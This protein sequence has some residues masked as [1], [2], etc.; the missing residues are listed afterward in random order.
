MSLMKEP[1]SHD[2]AMVNEL[3]DDWTNNSKRPLFLFDETRWSNEGEGLTLPSNENLYVIIS[4]TVGEALRFLG[5]L[6]NFY[7]EALPETWP[8][9]KKL[10]TADGLAELKSSVEK[11]LLQSKAVSAFLASNEVVKELWGSRPSRFQLQDKSTGK[12]RSTR[13][14]QRS[15][16]GR[17]TGIILNALKYVAIKMGNPRTVDAVIDPSGHSAFDQAHSR[18]PGVVSVADAVRLNDGPTG[19]EASIK[20]PTSFRLMFPGKST[21]LA[22]LVMLP[23]CLARLLKTMDDNFIDALRHSA[24]RNAENGEPRIGCALGRRKGEQ[25][26]MHVVGGENFLHREMTHVST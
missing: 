1:T 19:A 25:I 26:E 16:G 21:Y 17:E 18:D 11:A 7:P 13:T 14:G 6:H 4:T 5:E 24:M 23:D 10:W 20:T 15:F 2:E 3:V 9:S 22:G 8:K 12:L